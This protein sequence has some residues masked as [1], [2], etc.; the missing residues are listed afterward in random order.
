M[1]KI[2]LLL[3]SSC[4]LS[5]SAEPVNPVAYQGNVVH[6]DYLPAYNAPAAIAVTH[7]IEQAGMSNLSFFADASFTY[8]YIS[9]EGLKIA[10]NSVLNG[11][12]LSFPINSHT[13]FPSFQY[14]PGFK[15]GLGLINHDEWQYQIDYT[16]ARSHVGASNLNHTSGGNIP[17]GS[18]TVAT[19]T[20]VFI[21]DDWFLQGSSLGQALA[22][23]SISSHWTV[24]MNIVDF[25]AGRPFYQGKR[26]I[27]SPSGGLELA[28]I[29]Q[30]MNVSLYELVGQFSSLPAQPIESRTS[31]HSW[32]IGPTAGCESRYLLP[33][34]LYLNG[35]GSFS[36]LYTTYTTLKHS[37]DAASTAF[38][39]GPYTLSQ[40]NY[41][42]MRPNSSLELG[43][44]FGKYFCNNRCYFNL[45]CTYEFSIYWAQNMMRKLLDDYLTGTSPAAADLFTQGL[46]INTSINF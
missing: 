19:G 20:A 27:I 44:G 11:S 46:S 9:E 23:N 13:Y 21:S 42:A 33:W 41:H 7:K 45:S 22:A 38:N 10:S 16:W 34:N 2:T 31:S 1:Q 4:L 25:T 30:N 26:L 24:N 40:N 6:D 36:L 35:K 37:E 5:L 8:W 18:T 17:A 3:T 15:L 14:Q 12:L 29:S 39:P 43:L 32:G 28:F